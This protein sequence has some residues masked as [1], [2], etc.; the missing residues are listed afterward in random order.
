MRHT[1]AALA[2]V[3]VILTG[4]SGQEPSEDVCVTEERERFER[5]EEAAG[6]VS[7]L[8]E[9][10]DQQIG[11]AL[12]DF[13][14]SQREVRPR[15]GNRPSV[16]PPRQPGLEHRAWEAIVDATQQMDRAAQPVGCE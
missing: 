13:A 2:L 10:N 4:C 8:V 9:V 1:A 16:E 14:R 6:A 15:G 7:R 12:R 3:G 11:A 5:I